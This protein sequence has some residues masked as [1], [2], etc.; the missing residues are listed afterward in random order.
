M[1]STVL[2]DLPYMRKGLSAYRSP[3]LFSIEGDL[4]LQYDCMHF[5]YVFSII[6]EVIW[7]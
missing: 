7:K 6:P 2:L 4:S 3:E 5:L 1:C